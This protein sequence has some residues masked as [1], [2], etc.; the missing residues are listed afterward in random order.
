[1]IVLINLPNIKYLHQLHHFSYIHPLHHAINSIILYL[2]QIEI[3]NDTFSFKYMKCGWSH[4]LAIDY[5]GKL[6][7][8]GRNGYGQCG[9]G[10]T[11]NIFQ[12]TI[13]QSLKDKKIKTIKCGGYHCYVLSD[14]NNHY[15]W[16]YNNYNH[17]RLRVR[18]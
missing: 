16:G 9:N 13:V 3:I 2:L 12:P 10:T 14:D 11:N 7:C 5:D 18:D 15:L 1:M 4:N 6:Y 17:W 8:W